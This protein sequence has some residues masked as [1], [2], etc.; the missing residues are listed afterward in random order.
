MVDTNPRYRNNRVGFYSDKT[1]DTLEIGTIIEVLKS[2]QNSFEH[3]KIPT[4]IPL[5][6]VTAYENINGNAITEVNPEFQYRG[7]LY[8]DGAEYNIK[9]YPAL[10]SII[11]NEY[12]GTADNGIT[13]TSQ[14]SGYPTTTTVTFSAPP[15]GI[16]S[17]RAIG[18]PIIS[19]GK[20]IGI[21][22]QS[23][24][25]GYVTAPSITITGTGGV[26]AA[27][28]VSRFLNGSILP[29][30]TTNVF[31]IWPETKMGTF[32]VPD[33][34]AKKIV[35]NGP[36]Y[37]VGTPT[38]GNSSLQVGI[39][40][41]DGKWY[42]DKDAQKQQ[43]S[44]GNV[45]TTGY[46]NVRDSIG[47]SIIGSQ[48][49][50]VTMDEKKLQGP[51][52]HSHY[53]LHC[54]ASQDA[55]Y[56]RKYTGDNYLR[57]YRA[58]TGKLNT[59]FPAGGLSYTHKHALFK[60]S[61]SDN[62]IASYDLFNFSGGDSGTGT[63]KEPGYY[64]ASGGIGSGTYELITSTPASIFL[65]FISSSVIGGRQV[66]TSGTPIFATTT[67]GWSAAGN[68]STTIPANIDS[69]SI[70]FA[71]GSG[72]GAAYDVA[73]N[74]GTS[75]TVV[76]GN[77]TIGNF[78][79][80]GGGGGGAAQTSASGGSPGNRGTATIGGSLAT[81]SATLVTYSVGVDANAGGNGPVYQA[82]TTQTPTNLGGS[83][84][85]APSAAG[86]AG[87]FSFISSTPTYGPT[88]YTT[89]TTATFGVSNSSYGLTNVTV[90]LYGGAG[91][92]CGN[93]GGFTTSS[94]GGYDNNFGPCS[95]GLGGLGKYVKLSMISSRL[96][97]KTWSLNVYPGP[98]GSGTSRG[99][100]TFGD[101]GFGGDGYLNNDGG[102]GGA[103]TVITVG[104]TPLAGAGGG[105]GGGA[106]GEGECGTDGTN[107]TQF[108]DTPQGTTENLFS[109]GGS[110]GGSYGC[111][112]GGGGGGGGGIGTAA[113]S[114]AAG[115]SGGGGGGN[116]DHG[117]GYGGARG[118]S[119]YR[120]DYFSL[121]TSANNAT[122]SGKVV[123]SY[124]TNES[125]WT[126]GGGGGGQSI[127]TT[128]DLDGD[129]V[130]ATGAQTISATVGSGG[131]G[132]SSGSYSTANGSDG[133]VGIE[134][135]TI[136]GYAGGTTNTTIGDIVISAS[137]GVE[138]YSAGA[139][140]G[141]T[142][143]FVLPTTQVPTIVFEGGSPTTVATATAVV[144]GNRV[145]SVTLNSGGSGYTS[146][147][148]VRFLHGAGSGTTA[149]ATIN[150][151][152]VVS[153]LTLNTTTNPSTP[154]TKYV[155]FAG[156]D[157]VRFIVLAEQDCTNVKRF[158]VKAAR[159]N[160]INGGDLPESG[161]E[162]LQLFYNTDSTNNFPQS[163]YL[164]PLV[165]IPSPTDIATNYDGTSGNTQW[166]TYSIDLPSTVQTTNVRFKIVQN[167]NTASGANDNAGDTDQYGI[168]DFIFENKEVTELQ[169]VSTP[170][171]I[172]TSADELT[173]EVGGPS[174]STYTTG[175][176]ANDVS[177]SLTSATPLVPVPSISP[178]IDVPLL[179]PYVL[180]KHLIKAF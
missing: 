72:S 151:S 26:G 25:S 4:N 154:Y 119:S 19:A 68:Y 177:F 50:K 109:G 22:I 122:G 79:A 143:G 21:D 121:V 90:E 128:V 157:L 173:Y 159:G 20:I 147:P 27:A 7:Y 2:D 74:A 160:G 144:S 34:L 29:V 176:A 87:T 108:G 24:G 30:T 62:T 131:A 172:S 135:R 94:V 142:T 126:S 136:T 17:V 133:Y 100:G 31:S 178:D 15:A 14:G 78:T 86:S 9:D 153:A 163:Q 6:G 65:K 167:R 38:I 3:T 66:T 46:T 47:A 130:A 54:E 91:A 168:C 120:S 70:Q 180:V 32:N 77:S 141:S 98:A 35:G 88:E 63:I 150:A 139:G 112:G 124:T 114:T 123:I 81:A 175:M 164:G 106:A 134:F 43:F 161:G 169:F 99:D 59:F 13:I 33:L 145:S 45:T 162:E 16:G 170:G 129:E 67:V 75:T 97:T 40:S 132:V 69:I 83:G 36:V 85:S 95:T 149:T 23:Y 58:S 102:G 28:Q 61:L 111:T 60:K 53:L 174:N 80:S 56:A 57:G 10:Y 64:W 12:G 110:T 117:A 76:V 146:A 104:S 84:G 156:T 137:N 101:G 127:V 1:S 103:A 115:G 48:V 96:A 92:T 171:R 105:G 52:N 11:G 179:E 55:A 37:G 125:Y 41:I 155:K 148:T 73:G 39:N 107:N 158:S 82:A 42:L 8:C 116:G 166:Y 138:I 51:P 18:T 44:L 49:I 71:A 118:L 152:G 113:Q 165:P 140:T 5:N 89:N 93:F